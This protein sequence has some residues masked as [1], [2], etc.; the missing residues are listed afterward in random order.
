MFRFPN[1][2]HVMFSREFAFC[3][4]INYAHICLWMHVYKTTFGVPSRGLKWE[5]KKYKVKR[6][7]VSV[8]V[9]RDTP[10]S[11]WP[12]FPPTRVTVP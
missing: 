3:L 2:D 7:I 12:I 4:F 10:V 6:S 8:I 9:T 11:Y 1:S 5:N